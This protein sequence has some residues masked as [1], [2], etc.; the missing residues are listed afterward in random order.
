[1]SEITAC[2]CKKILIVEDNLLIAGMLKE[3][4]ESEGFLARV[5]PDG[6]DALF[7]IERER[8]DV[9]LL[10]LELPRLSGAEVCKKIRRN[11]TS[12]LIIMVTGRTSEADRI[13][14][15]VI[16]ADHYLTKPFDF[17]ALLKI[18]NRHFSGQ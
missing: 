9:L 14:G 4:L 1:M 12:I 17:K 15:R 16:G 13:I 3:S 2:G 7:Q 18:I 5:S 11:D 10:D 8:P 6:L